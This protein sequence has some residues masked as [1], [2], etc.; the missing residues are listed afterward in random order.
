LFG[1]TPIVGM[2]TTRK[3]VLPLVEFTPVNR[4]PTQNA[5]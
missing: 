3:P 2:F 1:A 4:M 5:P